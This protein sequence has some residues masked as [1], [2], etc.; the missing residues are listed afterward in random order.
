LKIF[1]PSGCLEFLAI[2]LACLT[3]AAS[4]DYNRPYAADLRAA[5]LIDLK[6]P[7]AP[8][9]NPVFT[10]SLINNAPRNVDIRTYQMYILVKVTVIDAKGT[11][12]DPG[13][14]PSSMR[15][16]LTIESVAPGDRIV[17]QDWVD[18]LAPKTSAIPLSSFGYHLGSG[19]Y[20]VVAQASAE[21]PKSKSCISTV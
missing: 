2:L 17:L 19:L 11:V 18:P 4:A 16:P 13:S 9:P 8:S 12:V 10:F 6:C 14:P 1:E 21:S 20:Q 7:Q 15:T 5:I 3:S